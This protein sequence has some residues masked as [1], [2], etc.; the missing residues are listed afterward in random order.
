MTNSEAVVTLSSD[1][2][3]IS[4]LKT[5]KSLTIDQLVEQLPQ[6]R[7]NEIFHAIDRLSRQGSIILTRQGFE[8]AVAL[9]ARV[10]QCA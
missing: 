10:R 9:P 7:W 5:N 6:L 8:Y 2:L 4:A 1:M 3:L